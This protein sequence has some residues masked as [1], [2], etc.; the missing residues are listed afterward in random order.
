MSIMRH[1]SSRTRAAQAQAE[2]DAADKAWGAELQRTFGRHAGNARYEKRGR[3]E[4]G[5]VLRRLHD[6]RQQACNTFNAIFGGN[7][8]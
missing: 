6:A 4:E 3:G 7:A 1:A 5:T 2:F 8:R